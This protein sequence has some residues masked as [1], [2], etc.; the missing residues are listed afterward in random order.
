MS[1]QKVVELL[2]T[3]DLN[4]LFLIEPND[5]AQQGL[6]PGIAKVGVFALGLL[7]WLQCPCNGPQGATRYAS[8]PGHTH[9][10]P[11]PQQTPATPDFPR[12]VFF[13]SQVLSQRAKDSIKSR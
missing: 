13:S 7:A 10:K 8:H 6:P 1:P 2:V 12:T 9:L 11:K 3:W 4:T 5:P